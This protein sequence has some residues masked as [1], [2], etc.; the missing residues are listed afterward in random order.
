MDPFS[1]WLISAFTMY[2]ASTPPL[3][4]K[5]TVILLPEAAGAHSGIVI[6]SGLR[7]S[8]ITEPYQGLELSGRHIKNK[9]FSAEEVQ[10]RFSGVMQALPEKP[11]TFTL[12][13]DANRTELSEDD[14]RVFG[15]IYLEIGKR[16]SPEITV[17][18]HTDSDGTTESN[19]RLSQERAEAVK[20]ML[21]SKGISAQIIQ[22]VGRGELEPYIRTQDGVVEPRNRR[23]EVIVR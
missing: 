9:A 10:L 22:S 23:V 15:E 2:L 12:F 19:F 11:R 8:Q 17:I 4:V 13:F 7:E 3:P 21:V 16:V 20:A 18:G 14:I 5:E 1:L 6:S